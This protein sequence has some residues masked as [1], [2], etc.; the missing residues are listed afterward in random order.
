[1]NFQIVFVSHTYAG[2]DVARYD[3][4]GWALNLTGWAPETSTY[5]IGTEMVYLNSEGW[6]LQLSYY[7]RTYT[8]TKTKSIN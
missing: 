6:K 5:I 1:M 3:N 7:Y 4:T 8:C 2:A